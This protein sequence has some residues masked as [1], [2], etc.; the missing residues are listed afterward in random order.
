MSEPE[1][2][3]QGLLK[4]QYNGCIFILSTALMGFVYIHPIFESWAF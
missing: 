1:H 2:E 4:E 3:R